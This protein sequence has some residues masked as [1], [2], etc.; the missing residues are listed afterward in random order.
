[1]YLVPIRAARVFVVPKRP[2]VPRPEPASFHLSSHAP[3]KQHAAKP[4]LMYPV[5]IDHPP[6]R[7]YP[8]QTFVNIHHGQRQSST[9]LAHR[10][11]ES[12]GKQCG[13]IPGAM[14]KR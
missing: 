12:F 8:K 14:V 11:V 9:Q 13:R 10:A 6:M 5:A 1:M 4:R 2:T 3:R 7:R